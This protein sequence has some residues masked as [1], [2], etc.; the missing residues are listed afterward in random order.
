MRVNK[1]LISAA[2]LIFI[3]MIAGAVITSRLEVTPDANSSRIAEASQSENAAYQWGKAFVE[4]T[5]RVRP[6]V[7]TIYSDKKIKVKQQLRQ[8]FL[9]QFGDQ[10]PDGLDGF[11]NFPFHFFFGP[12]TE[13]EYVQKGLGSGVIVSSEGYILTNNHVVSDVDRILVQMQGGKEYIAEVVGTD[14]QTDIAVLKID[15]KDLVAVTIGNSDELEVGELVLAIGSPLG[16]QQ[17]VTMGIVSATGRYSL[18]LPGITFEDFIQTDAAINPGNSGGPLLNINGELIGI[19]T[20][21]FSPTGTSAGIGFAVPVDIVNRVVP[22]IIKYGRII[23]PGLGVSI[24]NEQI[25]AR[26]DIKGVLIINIQPGSVAEDSG[27]RG[28]RRSGNDIVLGD[29]IEEVNGQPIT[30]YDDLRNEFDKY[31]V[32]DEVTLGILRGKRHI[33]LSINLEEVGQ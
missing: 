30:S 4:I 14:A 19:N 32:G 27:L 25:A 1:A 8:P 9:E 18:A 33:S 6:S 31:R 13:K 29:I 16:L 23:R 15:A 20:A 17:T 5:K 26:L 21:I 10:D 3:G 2:V 24:A 28:T 7:V 22:E 11:R 12:G